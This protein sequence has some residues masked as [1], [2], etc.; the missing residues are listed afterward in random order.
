VARLFKLPPSP[1]SDQ[2]PNLVRSKAFVFEDPHSRRLLEL[3]ARVASSDATV[4]VS[5]ET[6]TG[7]EIVA[8]HVHDR[9]P[10]RD[11]PFCAV[12]CGA[13]PE[14][15]VESEL[16][17]YERG[18]FTGANTTTQGWFEAAGGGTLFLDE[19]G[20]LTATAQVK[21]LRVLQEREIVRLGSRRPIPIDVR[22]IAA[23]NVNLAEAVAAKRF[24]EDLYY[25]LRVAAIHVRPL[26]ERRGDIL[27][28][29]K[30]FIELYGTQSGGDLPLLSSSA[31]SLLA[32]HPWPG[33]IRELENAIRHALLVCQHGRIA[34]EDLA[35]A[36]FAPPSMVPLWMVAR[37]EPEDGLTRALL[38]L[39]EQNPSHLYDTLQER[40]FRTAYQYTEQN[41]L[42]T[43]KLLGISR[44]VVRARLAQF[45]ETAKVRRRSTRDP[46]E[47]AQG[48]SSARE[49]RRRD[50]VAVQSHRTV[51]IGF[52]KYWLLALVKATGALQK[53][54]DHHGV[55]VEWIEFSGGIQLV[56]A[57]RE[58]RIELGVVGEGPPILAQAAS[59]PMVYV[60]AE[61]PAPGGEAIVVH[62]D[63]P[64]QRVADL[65]GRTIALTEGA[66]VHFLLLRAL[67]EAKLS[68]D[69]V[70]IVFA[71]PDVA[72][73]AFERRAIDAW[74]IWD[75]FLASIQQV[76]SARVL[77]DARGLATNTLYYIGARDFVDRQRELVDLFLT[78]IE[79]VSRWA[80]DHTADA[81]ELLAR[82]L[83]FSPAAWAAA[84]SRSRGPRAL[85]PELVV[86]QQEVA[87]AFFNAR[88]ISRPVS[89]SHA[90]W[91]GAFVQP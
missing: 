29:A 84:L 90:T 28:L 43:A 34:P 89:V 47:A 11:R 53:A 55:R 5:G 36:P 82:E 32:N 37:K 12:N 10:R 22:L 65:K 21:L 91:N 87:D 74:A 52:Q 85:G 13:L 67:D 19:I 60:G 64:V 81:V 61:R 14:A 15:L 56:E 38:E 41:Q 88:V 23:T 79:S 59:A 72:R 7:K 75:P 2:Q 6:G 45:G 77:R 54:M 35:I 31:E 83:G 49:D 40:I 39:F 58:G 17:G 33:N 16:F 73:A 27:P 50:G 78:E 71:A 66:N 44:N 1:S 69:D 26:R 48:C 24:R 20:E 80:T 3:L 42:Q 70:R 4:V 9:S 76:T 86:L 63:S 30:H 25:R 51:R 46:A 57:M 62:D 18:A 8:R 68:Y